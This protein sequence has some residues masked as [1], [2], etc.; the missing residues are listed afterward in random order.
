[1]G[2]RST[3]GAEGSTSTSGMLSSALEIPISRAQL[4]KRLGAGLAAAMVSGSFG[5][6]LAVSQGTSLPY[7]VL[8]VL[9]G[10]RPDYLN[11]SDIPQPDYL[12]VSDIPHLHRMMKNGTRYTQAFAGILESETPSGHLAIGTGSMPS[13]TG[14]PSFWWADRDNQRVSLFSPAT[15]RAGDME[16][17]IREAGVP[18]L[19]QLVHKKSPNSKVVALSGSKYYAADAIG[20]PEADVTMYFQGTPAGEYVPTYIP[21]HAPPPGLLSS[22]GVVTKNSHMPLGLENH[23]AMKLAASAFD[24]MRQQV[25]L[26]NLPEFDWPLGHIDGGVVDPAAVKALMQSFDRDLGML[27]EAYREA[28]VLGRTLFV[29]MSD[30]GMTPLAHKV[31]RSDIRSAVSKAGTGLVAETYTTGAYLW[32]EDESLSPL[33]AQNIAALNNPYIQS[34]YA[35]CFLGGRRTY[36]RAESSQPVGAETETANQYLLD[37]F[38][39][40]NAPDVVVVFAEGTGCEPGG[41]A[42][43]KA[44]HGGTSWEAQHIPLIVSGPGIRSNYVSTFPAR[45]IDVA[46]TVLLAMGAEDKGMQGI[47]LADALTTPRSGM[48][49]QQR[50]TSKSLVPI[51]SALQRQSR[52]DAVAGL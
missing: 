31:S 1:M 16:K 36:V 20:G 40:P 23:L 6:E 13:K 11:V 12:N 34:V 27:Q 45:L 9:D 41:Q 19:A 15:I 47:P 39:G 25:T 2:G 21:G 22:P 7:V 18:T 29:V 17:L 46:P 38:N 32:L 8:I 30:H 50:V 33:V 14:I 24:Q 3:A 51:V 52:L 4:L 49:E 28:G 10:A 43:W 5:L 42:N 37:S 48:I 44:D 26:I 35:G